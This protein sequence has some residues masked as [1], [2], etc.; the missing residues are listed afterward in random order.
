MDVL[1]AILVVALLWLIF[2]DV[3]IIIVALLIAVLA[4]WVVRSARNTRQ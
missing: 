4:L 1:V 2:K 3:T